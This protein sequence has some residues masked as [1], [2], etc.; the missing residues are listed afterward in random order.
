MLEEFAMIGRQVMRRYV[1]SLLL[2]LIGTS[3]AVAQPFTRRSSQEQHDG[4]K[5]TY[6]IANFRLGGK[7]DLSDPSKWV[8]GGEG[9]VTLGDDLFQNRRVIGKFCEADGHARGVSRPRP[10][11]KGMSAGKSE[12][13]S[14]RRSG[15]GDG[16]AGQ[17]LEQ[18][19]AGKGDRFLL[20]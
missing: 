3:L 6:E 19:G 16:A 20:G 18:L 7:Y 17:Q 11:R 2:L 10:K 14:L 8:N 1:I 9:G 15:Q 13:V 5:K 12:F 4:L